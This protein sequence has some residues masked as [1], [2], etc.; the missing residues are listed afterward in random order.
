MFKNDD[1]DLR[2][3]GRG[4]EEKRQDKKDGYDHVNLAM[5]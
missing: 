4:K 3:R 2:K 5:S 1:E